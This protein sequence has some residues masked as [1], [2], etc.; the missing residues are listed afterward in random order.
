MIPV[1]APEGSSETKA[2]D[3][4]H[5]IGG[6]A[7]VRRMVEL[8]VGPV[9]DRVARLRAGDGSDSSELIM[10]AHSLKTSAA[11]VG[12]EALLDAARRAEAEA[13]DADSEQLSELS[14]QLCREF[15][16]A[17]RELTQLVAAR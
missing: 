9:G 11:I 6:A 16:R 1:L 3:R 15:D 13:S 12:A 10:V 8:F 4:L 17:A 7:L 5:R 2:L 14:E